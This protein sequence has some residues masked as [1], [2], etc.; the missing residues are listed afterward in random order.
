M[1]LVNDKLQSVEI[2]DELANQNYHSQECS[3][4]EAFESL[5]N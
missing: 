3:K 1:K 2:I 5:G 4:L